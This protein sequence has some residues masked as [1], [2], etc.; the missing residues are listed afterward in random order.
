MP[1]QMKNIIVNAVAGNAGSAL[2]KVEQASYLILTS[3][4]Y[5]VW[6]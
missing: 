6:H 3:N 1:A 5:N 2:S 4:Y